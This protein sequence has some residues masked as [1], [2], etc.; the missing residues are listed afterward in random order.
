MR[1][2]ACLLSVFAKKKTGPKA[3]EEDCLIGGISASLQGHAMGHGPKKRSI[4]RGIGGKRHRAVLTCGQHGL[5]PV[6]DTL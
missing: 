5:P 4:R 1:S 3:G 6:S 2:S